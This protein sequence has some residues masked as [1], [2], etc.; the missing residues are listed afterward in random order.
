M[1]KDIDLL[2]NYVQMCNDVFL[3]L[4]GHKK[5]MICCYSCEW[6]Q[7]EKKKHEVSIYK[8]E[9]RGKYNRFC[10]GVSRRS[11]IILYVV[12]IGLASIFMGL[13]FV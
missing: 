5:Q 10:D 3:C 7:I 9:V 11:L 12:L 8:K 1:C 4:G 13:C 6:S 2:T